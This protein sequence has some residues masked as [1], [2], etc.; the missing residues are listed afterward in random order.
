MGRRYDYLV[1]LDLGSHATRCVVA[2]EEGSRLRFI[3]HGLAPSEGWARGVIASQGPV[4]ASV[5]KA[6]GDAE[7]NGG[8]VVE[9]AVV[10]VGGAHV[11][12][13]VCHS[14]LQLTPEEPEVQQSH[15]EQVIQKAA[16]GPL[17]TDRTAVQVVPL[18]FV[19][20][21]QIQVHNPRGMTAHRLDG[22]VQVVSAAAQAHNNIRAVVNRAGVVV[23]E[24][25]FEGFAAAHAVLEEQEREMGVA[26]AD[27]GAGS[28]DLAAYLDDDLCLAV[29]IPLG[30][31]HFVNDVAEVLRTSREDAEQLIMQY[32]CA[33]ADD[34]PANVTI[35][36]PVLGEAKPTNHPRRLLNEILQARAEEAFELIGRELRRAR[37]EGHLI[38]GLVLTGSLAGLA[39]GCDVAERVLGCST[40]IGLPP[41]IEDWPDELD[42]PGWATA[43]GLVLYAQRLRLHRKRRRERAREWLNAIFD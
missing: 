30:G 42:H 8:M 34:T 27:L 31:D 14:S 11:T 24:T 23:E 28:I 32:G 4:L 37:L 39:G 19:L 2:L 33:V 26:V 9:V 6:I 41:R 13:N 38:A 12:S 36:V 25:V 5:E 10:G 29:G 16:Q 20:D 15:V 1:G 18:E 40:R 3:S 21:R 22:H 17:S 43:I 35:E 7:R